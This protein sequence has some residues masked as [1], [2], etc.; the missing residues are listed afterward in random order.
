MTTPATNTRTEH[1]ARNAAEAWQGGGKA[2][3]LFTLMLCLFL[4]ALDQTIIAPALP[5]IGHAFGD[6][7][8]LSW[9]VSAFFLTYTAMAPVF[10]RLS[11]IFGRRVML[12]WALGLFIAGSVACALAPNMLVLIFARAL[13]GLGGGGIIPLVVTIVSDL[14]PARERGHYQTYFS[15]VWV[16]AGVSGPVLGGLLADLFHWSMIF[17]INLPLGALAFA[18]LFSRM[19]GLPSNHMPRRVDVPGGVLLMTAAIVFV[20]ALTWGGVR[21]PWTSQVILALLGV[22]F[23]L[24]IVFVFYGLRTT[25]PFLPPRMLTGSVV[26]QAAIGSACATGT[27]VGMSVILPVHFQLVHHLSPGMSG[28]ALM[29]MVALGV[30]GALLS[31]QAMMRVRRYKYV[32]IVF[33]A[34]AAAAALT[35]FLFPQMPLW[36]CLV[37]VAIIGFGQGTQFPLATIAVQNAV[38]PH[39]MG[40]AAGMLTF[41]RGLAGAV[42]VAGFTSILLSQLDTKVSGTESADLVAKFF[43]AGPDAAAHSLANVFLAAAFVLSVSAVSFLLMEGRPLEGRT[44]AAPASE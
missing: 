24:T 32:A 39:E 17:W 37:C 3:I 21:F 26:P 14:V 20:L 15:G 4:A 38:P 33:L 42:A 13:Q 25:D 1:A 40:T 43:A 5:T 11:D 36:A 41:F 27:M 35:L 7:E 16:V 19:R 18:L 30:P 2:I 34:V 12:F 22:A 29:P 28:I 44:H 10:G 8:N 6:F 9:T 23:V 31:G